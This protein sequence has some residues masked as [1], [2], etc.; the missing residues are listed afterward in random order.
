MA[1]PV[2]S[3][4]SWKIWPSRV[5]LEFCTEMCWMLM[6]LICRRGSLGGFSAHCWRSLIVAVQAPPSSSVGV[7]AHLNLD[8]EVMPC[9]KEWLGFCLLGVRSACWI[10]SKPV[11]VNSWW[12]IKHSYEKKNV[13]SHFSCLNSAFSMNLSPFLL[14]LQGLDKGHQKADG[15]RQGLARTVMKNQTWMEWSGMEYNQLTSICSGC[16]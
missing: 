15:Q 14:H 12:R 5:E 6:M 3:D 1:G 10:T 11:H 13:D 2:R 7:G 4:R 9:A 16:L 8:R